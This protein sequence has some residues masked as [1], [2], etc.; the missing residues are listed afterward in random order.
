[1]DHVILAIAAYTIYV[2]IVLGQ[3]GDGGPQ[4]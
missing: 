1:V 2:V 3:V 4:T